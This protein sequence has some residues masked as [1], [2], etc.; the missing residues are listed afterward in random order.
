MIVFI[1]TNDCWRLFLKYSCRSDLFFLFIL[2]RTVKDSVM[3]VDSRVDCTGLILLKNGLN[4]FGFGASEMILLL[5]EGG[6]RNIY[7]FTFRKKS[8]NDDRRRGREILG[9]NG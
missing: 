9:E 3:P 5:W 8:N 2:R 4:R 6:R 7:A 1:F